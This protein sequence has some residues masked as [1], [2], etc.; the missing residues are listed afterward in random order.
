MQIKISCLSL[1][2]ELLNNNLL[3]RFSKYSFFGSTVIPK[4][5]KLL[6]D[7][8]KAS[9]THKVRMGKIQAGNKSCK[10]KLCS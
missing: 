8:E 3:S 6:P 4:M 10:S 7:P 9:G 5:E 1:S 2:K